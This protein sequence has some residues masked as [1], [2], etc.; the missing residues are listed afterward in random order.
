MGSNFPALDI[1][2]QPGPI[3]QLGGVM[4]LK[5]L[6]GQLAAQPGQLQL[7]QQQIEAQKRALDD[8]AAETAAMKEWAEGQGKISMDAL[9]GLILKHG[10]S[11][12]ASLSMKNN[13]LKQQQTI[14]TLKKE[15]RDQ[16]LSQ[17]TDI[18]NAASDILSLAP[19]LRPAAY[20]QKQQELLARGSISAQDAKAPYDEDILKIHAAGSAHAKEQLEIADKQA[21]AAAAALNAKTAASRLDWEKGGGGAVDKQEMSDW[22]AKNPGKGPSDFMAYKA[23]L[24]PAFNFNLQQG[25][26]GNANDPMTASLAQKVAGG[27]MKIADVLTMRTPLAARK[28]FLN[29]VLQINPNFNSSDY[30]IEKGVA[31]YM[32]SGEGGK[33][34]TAF[35]T[36]IEH[37]KQLDEAA[38]A[39]S[40]GDNRSLNKIGNALGYEFGS[41]RTTNFN[42]IK[43]ALSGEISKVFKGGQATDA[44]IKEVQ[45]P[46]DAANSPAQLRGAIR[47]A[48]RLMGS[49]RDALKQQYEQGKQA[50]P[51]F[52]ESSTTP[53][54]TGAPPANL[55]KEG[56]HT[57][58]KNGQTWTLQNGKAVQ[59]Q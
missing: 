57:T 4:Q 55:L 34:L 53:S 6:Q 14:Q 40:I 44:E 52:G 39:L 50:K 25:G 17:A 49:K 42:V 11:A 26:M 37:A 16:A 31:K 28:A 23:K 5:A 47:N 38:K 43:N 13:L 1:K 8:K 51:N 27:Q 24:V 20:A 48:V 15:Q 54:T 9:P 21:T 36:A 58:F 30:D 33:N 32:T 46:F 35:N 3:E 29:Q 59:V 41:D 45:G 19:E 10:G 22:L 12:D 2:Q 18:N 56:I 7:Q